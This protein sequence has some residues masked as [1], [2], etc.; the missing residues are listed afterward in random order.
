M[1]YCIIS[2]NSN[3]EMIAWGPF[4]KLS[5]AKKTRKILQRKYPLPKHVLLN[6]QDITTLR[7]EVLLNP[8]NRE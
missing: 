2:I 1:Q 5:S 6:F 7:D 8:G 3:L 4:G